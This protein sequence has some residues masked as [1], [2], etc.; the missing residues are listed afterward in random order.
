MKKEN[1]PLSKEEIDLLDKRLKSYY[2]NPKNV[3]TWDEFKKDLSKKRKA[4]R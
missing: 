3:R 4:T 2:Q 1:K